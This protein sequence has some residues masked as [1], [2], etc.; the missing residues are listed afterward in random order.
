MAIKHEH[1]LAVM[2][3]AL[4]AVVALQT[5]QLVDLS[6]KIRGNGVA[7]NSDGTQE[8]YDQMMQRMHGTSAA[9]SPAATSS[10][11]RQVGGC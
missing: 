8:T 6:G 1:V 5:V 3:V 4:I 10:S 9:S 7:A 11:P 2:L